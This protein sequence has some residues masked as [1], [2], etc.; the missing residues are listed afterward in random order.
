MLTSM[1]TLVLMLTF[2]RCRGTS[3]NSGKRLL[4]LGTAHQ[5]PPDCQAMD[6][7]RGLVGSK[8]WTTRSGP[9]RKQHPSYSI[10]PTKTC[11][12]KEIGSQY[13]QVGSTELVL[14]LA[15]LTFATRCT[16]QPA[17]QPHDDRSPA[18]RIRCHVFLDAC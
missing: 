3:K 13:I 14:L 18:A 5:R 1:L 12:R 4:L 16:F 7:L 6:I 11:R 9:S 8:R 17:R 15:V 2:D 10:F